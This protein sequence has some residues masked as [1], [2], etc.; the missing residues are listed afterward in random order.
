VSTSSWKSNVWETRQLFDLQSAFVPELVARIAAENPEALAVTAG[1]RFGELDNRAN[2]L[3]WYLR[4][5]G[6][7]TDVVVG[8]CLPR[9]LNMVVGTLGILKAGGAYVPIDPAWPP[10]RVAFVLEEAQ[11]PAL[12][13]NA[14]LVRQ[15]PLGKQVIVDLAAPQIRAQSEGPPVA[16]IRGDDLAYVIY[17]SGSTGQPKGVEISHGGLANLV[18]WHRQAFSV[19]S[20]DRASH[21]AGL[22]FDAA[23]WELWPYLAAGASVHLVDEFARNSAELLQDWLV[24]HK[25]TISFVPTP[26]PPRICSG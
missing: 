3:A 6:V 8:L 7:G 10:D 21:L 12:I 2:R 23:V 17:T 1:L 4:S 9:C 18:S 13:T 26:L 22:S 11:S 24:A 16:K 5:L 20:A 25:I 19:T 14:S 15:I